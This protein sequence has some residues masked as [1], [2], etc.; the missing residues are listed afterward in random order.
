MIGVAFGSISDPITSDLD[1][2]DDLVCQ[3]LKAADPT[4]TS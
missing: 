3:S 2:I 1:D 4:A